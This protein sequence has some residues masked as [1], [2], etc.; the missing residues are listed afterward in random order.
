VL[1]SPAPRRYSDRIVIPDDLSGTANLSGN[2]TRLPDNTV[3][4]SL[5]DG[6]PNADNDRKA[7]EPE[8]RQA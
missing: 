3:A 1:S 8:T 4:L 5:Y 6:M 7:H 2:L